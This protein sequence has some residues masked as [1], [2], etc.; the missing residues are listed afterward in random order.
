MN[1]ETGSISLKISGQCNRNKLFF[2]PVSLENIIQ[3]CKVL[4]KVWKIGILML[5]VYYK[6]MLSFLND[7]PR[8]N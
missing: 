3:Y 2:S 6:V 4:S 7:T 5:L 1:I 8:A